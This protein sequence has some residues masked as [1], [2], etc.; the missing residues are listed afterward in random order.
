MGT[1]A[2]WASYGR[3]KGAEETFQVSVPG[4]TAMPLTVCVAQP[5]NDSRSACTTV[6][7]ESSC[8]GGSGTGL[9]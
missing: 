1:F 6:T 3:T 2:N 4:A 5:G 9:L 8:D 7:V